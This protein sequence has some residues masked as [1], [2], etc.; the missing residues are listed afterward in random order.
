[1]NEMT[2]GDLR[3]ILQPFMDETEIFVQKD[4]V[5]LYLDE[6]KA[7]YKHHETLGE[8]VVVLVPFSEPSPTTQR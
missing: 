8:G 4:G 7:H 1:M 6:E 5:L 2:A 3:R